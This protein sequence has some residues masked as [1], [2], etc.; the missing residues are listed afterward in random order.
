MHQKKIWLSL[1]SFII[2]NINIITFVYKQNIAFLVIELSK[3]SKKELYYIKLPV[4]I[5]FFFV[6]FYLF[7]FNELLHI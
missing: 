5:C 7:W 2:I 3:Y 1:L 6:F 4:L